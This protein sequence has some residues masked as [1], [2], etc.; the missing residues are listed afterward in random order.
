MTWV[1]SGSSPETFVTTSQV[2]YHF[3]RMRL[4]RRRLL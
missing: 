3:Q 1:S 2:R 4:Q